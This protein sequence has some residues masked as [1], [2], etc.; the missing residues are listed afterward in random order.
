MPRRIRV[1]TETV[2]FVGLLRF[3]QHP[4]TQSHDLGMRSVDFLDPQ[5]QVDLLARCPRRPVRCDVV[6]C[7]LHPHQRHS[8]E[9]HRGAPSVALKATGGAALPT[10]D[11]RPPGGSELSSSARLGAI[12]E[13]DGDGCVWCSRP[14]D[15]LIAPTRERVIARQGWT[16]L[17]RERG[18]RVRPVQPGARAREPGPVARRGPPARSGAARTRHRGRA[19]PARRAHPDARRC[20]QDAAPSGSRVAQASDTETP[21]PDVARCREHDTLRACQATSRWTY[22]LRGRKM[23]LRRHHLNLSACASGARP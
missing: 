6:W 23:H 13:R 1:H 7:E 2:R 22:G 20:P 8:T 12:V 11:G 3:L 21:S 19:A 14:F 15:D 16:E 4:R 9:H 17:A 18:G 5:V 10:R